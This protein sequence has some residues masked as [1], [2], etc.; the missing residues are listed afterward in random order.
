MNKS[1]VKVLKDAKSRILNRK[2]WCKGTFENSRGAICASEAI[3]RSMSNSSLYR[4]KLP[5]KIFN[6]ITGIK[7][8]KFAISDFN[9][10]HTHQEVLDA[11]DMAIK[12]AKSKKHKH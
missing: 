11:F 9:D 7:G 5:Y 6:S 12:V 1:A 3:R 10:T 2:N 4:H 8:D